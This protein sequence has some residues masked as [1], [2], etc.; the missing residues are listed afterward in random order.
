MR[1]RLLSGLAVAAAGLAT[2][3]LGAGP[4]SAYASYTVDLHGPHNIGIYAGPGSANPKSGP[5]LFYAD[6]DSVMIVCYAWSTD[7]LGTANRIWF[8]LDGYIKKGAWTGPTYTNH[9]TQWVSGAYLY[10]ENTSNSHGFPL[11]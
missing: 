3:V 10:N 1:S 7:T 4:A 5:D 6:H 8:G 9:P 11:C 2:L